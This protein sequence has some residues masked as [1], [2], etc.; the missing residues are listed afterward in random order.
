MAESPAR[1]VLMLNLG[2]PETIEA[3]K[4]FLYRLFADPE[5]I[6]IPFAPLRKLVAWSIATAREKESQNLYRTIGGGSPIRKYT[7]LQAQGTEAR[8]REAG[9]IADVRTAFTCAP[10]LVE[11][12]VRDMAGRGVRRFLSFPLYPQYSFTTTRGALTRAAAA[13]HR[14]AP[15]SSIW[16]I[17]SWCAHPL[18]LRAHAAIIREALERFDPAAGEPIHLLFSA[19]SI[20]ETLV[21][22]DG[23]PYKDQIEETVAGVREAAGWTGPW[24]LAWQSRLGPIKWLEPSTPSEIERLAAA[25]VR[26]ILIVPI[27]FV[28]DH[29]ETLCEIDIQFAELARKAG[30]KEFIKTPGLNAHP[31]FLD[32]L[33]DIAAAKRDFWA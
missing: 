31:L 9:K 32:A 16:E 3:V 7:D 29:I 17:R 25:G 11:D 30:I 15:S 2:G 13:V 24:S 33:A 27:A 28:S 18:F 21:T 4:P 5:I 6:R 10:P 19:H 26:R 1:G 20:P 12:V 23:D 22:R 14:F 8:L